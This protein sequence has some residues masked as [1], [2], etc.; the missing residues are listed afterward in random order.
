MEPIEIE[1]IEVN[2]LLEAIFQRYGYDFRD[3]ARASIERRLSQ[4]LKDAGI[5]DLSTVTA[6]LLRD[7]VFFHRLVPY[8]SVS[9]TSLFRDPPFYKA[10]REKVVPVLRTWPRFKV[11]HAGCATG[12]EVYSVAIVLREAG[13]LDRAMLYGT[14][15]SQPALD[16]AKAGIYPLEILK[17]GS[18]NYQ[19][20]GGTGSLSDHY[21]AKYDVAVMNAALAKQITIARHNLAMDKSFGEVQMVVCRNV[22][23]YFNQDLQNLVLQLFLDS[24]DHGGFLC[25]GD[26]ESLSFSAVEHAFVAVDEKARIYKKRVM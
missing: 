26:K 21:H 20:S 17:Q 9:V 2:L 5:V 18:A 3:Y 10:L 1:R 16:T 23:I 14:D 11:W 19:K 15:I 6:Q 22:L 24:L 4:F 25:L 7:P 8:F 12:E 13:L